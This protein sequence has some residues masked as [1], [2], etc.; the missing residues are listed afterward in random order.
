MTSVET[1][2]QDYLNNLA[3]IVIDC[4]FAVHREMGPGLLESV[5]QHCMFRELMDQGISV[6]TMVEVPLVYKGN[7]LN[8]DFILDM[9]VEDEIIV[10]LKAV[11]G[12]MPVHQAQIISYLKLA[13]KRLGLLINFNVALLK[14]GIKRYVNKF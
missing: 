4:A 10:E 12:M 2:S 11:E 14:D 8:K 6:T 7:P 1:H 3:G 13:D 5:Y 9:L